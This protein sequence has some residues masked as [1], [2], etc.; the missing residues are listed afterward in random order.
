MRRTA[1][2]ARTGPYLAPGGKRDGFGSSNFKGLEKEI[3]KIFFCCT[4]KAVCL[5]ARLSR[6][7]VPQVTINCWRHH[8]Q[9]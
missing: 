5:M 1:A 4:A 2:G 7:R 9:G 8:I 6:F 3:V